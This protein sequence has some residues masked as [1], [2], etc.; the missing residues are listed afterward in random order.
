[1]SDNQ[2]TYSTH[3]GCC[4]QLE[5][6]FKARP[7]ADCSEGRLTQCILSGHSGKTPP[8]GRHCGLG[9]DFSKCRLLPR[10]PD[11]VVSVQGSSPQAGRSVSPGLGL[12]SHSP[13]AGEGKGALTSL[14]ENLPAARAVL[15]TVME[16]LPWSYVCMEQS[17][18]PVPGLGS[19]IPRITTL[20]PRS[21]C[22]VKGVLRPHPRPDLTLP[23]SDSAGR[24]QKSDMLEPSQ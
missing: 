13:G 16:T 1:M 14:F 5:F 20:R 15:S 3:C 9:P 22:R 10:L 17:P 11:G 7:P 8:A 19:Q 21:S 18:R 6:D 24:S 12:L 4:S 23:E 2:S